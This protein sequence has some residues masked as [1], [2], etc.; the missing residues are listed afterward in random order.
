MK[1]EERG[2]EGIPRKIIMNGYDQNI[3]Y[4][5]YIKIQNILLKF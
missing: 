1:L 5:K 3:F 4:N 2:T